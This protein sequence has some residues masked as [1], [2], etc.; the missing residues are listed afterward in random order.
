[1]KRLL[2]FALPLLALLPGPALAQLEW[3][4]L[5]CKAVPE[6]LRCRLERLEQAELGNTRPDPATLSPA[7]A[8]RRFDQGLDELV[9]DGVVSP[10]EQP[11][12]PKEQQLLNRIRASKAPVEQWRRFGQCSYDWSGWK[13]HPNGIRTTGVDCGGTAMRWQIGVS[14]DRLMVNIRSRD[15]TWNGWEPPAGPEDRFRQ[16]ED[17]M[18]ASL[19]AN[20]MPAPAP[21]KP[22]PNQS[23]EP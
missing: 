19:C 22:T 14:C 17:L 12:S 23:S 11:L 1:M 6:S 20:A 7:P 8:P 10:G 3:P 4:K 9:R 16:G 18:V 5:D 13:L 2:L 21:A 15:A